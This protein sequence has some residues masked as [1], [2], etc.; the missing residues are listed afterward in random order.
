MLLWTLGCVYLVKLSVFVVFSDIHLVTGIVRSRGGSTSLDFWETS[1]LLCT[2]AAPIYI[3]TNSGGFPF[4]HTLT[5]I[6]YLRLLMSV[7]LTDVR[8]YPTVVLICISPMG[9]S[10]WASFHV[11]VGHLVSWENVYSVLIHFL[12]FLSLFSILSCMNC[13]CW[14]LTLLVI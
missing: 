10:C 7:I 9:Q 12:I 6:C 13:L 14:I 4:L 11:P 2:V 3:P 1:I 5:N 8:W